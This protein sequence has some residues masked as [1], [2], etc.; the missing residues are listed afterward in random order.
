MFDG[1]TDNGGGG[2]GGGGGATN[3]THTQQPAA[4]PTLPPPHPA[5]ALF[6]RA[7]DSEEEEEV[8]G[9]GAGGES[10][11]GCEGECE[12][13]G[14]GETANEAGEVAGEEGRPFSA[15][16]ETTN[17]MDLFG[18]DSDTTP[19]GEADE[20]INIGAQDEQPAA[21]AV[22]PPPP[23][24]PA[25]GR[26]LFARA[27]SDDGDG[28]DDEGGDRDRNGGETKG[29][30]PPPPPHPPPSAARPVKT[31]PRPAY[32]G[33]PK[34]LINVCD[35][36]FFD[37]GVY[38]SAEN[39]DEA[40]ELIAQGINIDEQGGVKQWTAL[41][42]ATYHGYINLVRELIKAGA[43]LDVQDENQCTALHVAAN[44][45]EYARDGRYLALID[46]VKELIQ[47]G[48]ALDMLGNTTDERGNPWEGVTASAIAEGNCGHHDGQ[49]NCTS[50]M[51][52]LLEEAEA[53][54]RRRR[55]RRRLE[56]SVPGAAY[57]GDPEALIQLCYMRGYRDT[58]GDAE[59]ARD[60]IALGINVD[61]QFYEEQITALHVAAECG[62]IDIV[63]ELIRAGAAL[64][65]KD[66][67]GKTALQVRIA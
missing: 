10:K 64:D 30:D 24:P 37:G 18:R 66:S 53:A 31:H 62:H 3:D 50:E 4:A 39:T 33:D 1:T 23:P 13:G 45:E 26:A 54:A 60:L 63:R 49:G 21:E 17:N 19:E 42:Y 41:H 8:G 25:V 16:E 35:A 2:G 9:A 34:A 46:I 55:Q 11:G 67:D 40:L 65:V 7:D 51:F 38:I 59:E 43:A 47:A 15:R 36:G 14:G 58:S 44:C 61:E 20:D 57:E 32:D 27:V 5:V 22:E 6:M 28:G 56:S 12:G 48:A 52:T 29:E